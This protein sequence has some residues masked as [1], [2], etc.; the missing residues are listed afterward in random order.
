MVWKKCIAQ[1][2]RQIPKFECDNL[3]VKRHVGRGSF[4]EVFLTDFLDLDK[5]HPE[6]VV[7]NKM[8]GVLDDAE[9][10]CFHNKVRIMNDLR[11]QNIVEFKRVCFAPCALMMEYVYFSNIILSSIITTRNYK[12]K[13]LAALL[14]SSGDSADNRR[15]SPLIMLDNQLQEKSC[16]ISS[17]ALSSPP[18]GQWAQLPRQNKDG[19]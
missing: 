15:W 12:Q 3:E 9:T 10:K 7:I 19:R 1:N 11:H 14:I 8:L 5:S 13:G 18:L 4:S 17:H 6:R 2:M 16:F